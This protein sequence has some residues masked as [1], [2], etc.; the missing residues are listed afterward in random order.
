MRIIAGELKG[1]Q[2]ATVAD[3]HYRPTTERAREAI[4]SMLESMDC[5][6]HKKVLDLY[7]GTGSLG[8]EALSRGAG[9]CLFVENNPTLVSMLRANIDQLGLGQRASVECKSVEELMFPKQ[10]SSRREGSF[11]LVFADPPWDLQIGGMLVLDFL[12]SKLAS[13]PAIFVLGSRKTTE[14]GV[15]EAA[16]SSVGVGLLK[17]KTYGDSFIRIFQVS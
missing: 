15:T 16:L 5:V 7:S 9:S 2:I 4:F 10:N 12:N 6:S 17:E 14:L 13:K 8:F 11:S 1:R 3:L